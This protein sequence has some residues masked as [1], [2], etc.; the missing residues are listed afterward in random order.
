M[1]ARLITQGTEALPKSWRRQWI[2]QR[3]LATP[4]W[5]CFKLIRQV[6][7]QA[8]AM[9]ELTGVAHVVDHI[10]PLN[11]PRVCGLHV[12]WNLQVITKKHNGSKS[13]YFCPEQMD[14]F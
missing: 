4:P 5:A 13:N 1:R 7:Q 2:I 12:A 3:I 10:I 8:D 9:T 11:H 6:Y 14:L